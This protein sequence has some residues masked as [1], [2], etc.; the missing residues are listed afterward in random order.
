MGQ[1]G[2]STDAVIAGGQSPGA[3]AVCETWDGTCWSEVNNLN[4]PAFENAGAGTTGPAGIMFGGRTT[5][6]NTETW[7]GTCWTEINN[8]TSG[9]CDLAGSGSQTAALAYGGAPPPHISKTELWDG[10]S[11]T[12]QATLGTG[13]YAMQGIGPST[14]ALLCGGRQTPGAL[15][16]VEEWTTALTIKTVTVS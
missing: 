5:V 10:T 7:D 1:F 15:A 6:A 14:A 2:T 8:L 4:A 12:A 9:R 3:T 16:N 11:W 13:R